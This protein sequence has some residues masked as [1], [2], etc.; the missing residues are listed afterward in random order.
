MSSTEVRPGSADVPMHVLPSPGVYRAS[1]RSEAITS[2]SSLETK[3]AA[4]AVR[5][6]TA[7]T[8]PALSTDTQ[9]P[10]ASAADARRRFYQLRTLRRELSGRPSLPDHG[11]KPSSAETAAAP[12]LFLPLGSV[13]QTTPVPV[14]TSHGLPLDRLPVEEAATRYILRTAAAERALR[15]QQYENDELK[16]LIIAQQQE[17][18]DVR[19]Q[20]ER[21]TQELAASSQMVL[22]QAATMR[23]LTSEMERHDAYRLIKERRA[24]ASCATMCVKEEDATTEDQPTQQQRMNSLVADVA[25]LEKD[26]EGLEQRNLQ[27]EVR[28]Q[29]Q[30]K[31]R[32][33]RAAVASAAAAVETIEREEDELAADD[34]RMPSTCG[35]HCGSTWIPSA[36]EELQQLTQALGR[37]L[38]RSSPCGATRS[39]AFS[40]SSPSPLCPPLSAPDAVFE[41]TLSELSFTATTTPCIQS[42]GS[43]QHGGEKGEMLSSRH[44][45]G[46]VLQ[47]CGPYNQVYPLLRVQLTDSQVR[48]S[49]S[50]PHQN[51]PCFDD[52]GNGRPHHQRKCRFYALPCTEGVL[53]FCFFVQADDAETRGPSDEGGSPTPVATAT[54]AVRSLIAAERATSTH[55]AASTVH[56]IHLT[57]EGESA[58]WG[59]AT[60]AVRVRAVQLT[61]SMTDD[62]IHG[63]TINIRS[64]RHMW[65]TDGDVRADRLHSTLSQHARTAVT[66]A[67]EEGLKSAEELLRRRR[68]PLLSPP[69]EDAEEGG[70]LL[71]R[72]RITPVSTA[73]SETTT[74]I[75]HAGAA[76][77]SAKVPQAAA[78]PPPLPP[79]LLTTVAAASAV[80]S[81]E[82][83]VATD[84]VEEEKTGGGCSNDSFHASADSAEPTASAAAASF[85]EPPQ[86]LKGKE[87]TPTASL[88]PPSRPPSS[89]TGIPLSPLVRVP[90]RGEAAV[91]APP[92]SSA[93]DAA[94]AAA[95]LMA[96]TSSSVPVSDA[97]PSPPMEASIR[98]RIC[99]HSLLDL[100]C[101]GDTADVE[102]FLEHCTVRVR[103]RVAGRLVFT[104]P[105]R[106]NPAR[107]VW[108][109]DEGACSTAVTLTDDLRVEVVD[110][111]DG[112]LAQA[113][114]RASS[115]VGNWGERELSLMSAT[116]NVL[117]GTLVV[118]I[119]PEQ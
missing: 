8:I 29:K 84:A 59:A 110:A 46:G 20:L 57:R 24:S 63:N 44:G 104:A 2:S 19:Q 6:S 66:S 91:P 30:E 32:T 14:A 40:S 106:R 108:C 65:H 68:A 115:L 86:A 49:A 15:H 74:P 55:L 75:P 53:S 77:S 73:A 88:V 101:S 13:V 113:V 7:G 35:G 3:A 1:V 72:R 50:S 116:D 12:S 90:P 37:L 71:T 42:R 119:A 114:V 56:T 17:T 95:S 96:E 31:N 83:T 52:H 69:R 21:V 87:D 81:G 18:R 79:P 5:T 103:V 10:A 58:S 43:Q 39:A 51:R 4:E 62:S 48:P 28:P 89:A 45:S 26:K 98:V 92:T 117:C 76:G 38:R 94:T 78:S 60:L 99:L 111:A 105:P 36:A 118:S 102:G 70:G 23:A 54:V 109:A 107:A 11:E 100:H 34:T 22:R 85:V 27:K 64:E 82:G 47:V 112:V 67:E 93:A 41:V 33:A 25:Q 16:R 61:T 9:L 80:E 97:V